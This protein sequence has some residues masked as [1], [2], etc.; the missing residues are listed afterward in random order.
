MRYTCI[1]NIPTCSNEINRLTYSEEY[2]NKLHNVKQHVQSINTC[3]ETSDLNDIEFGLRFSFLR[4]AI[5]ICI[6]MQ[7]LQNYLLLEFR[8]FNV[9]IKT[10]KIITKKA[11]R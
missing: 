5:T 4:F 6:H 10:L 1:Q 7:M 3:D 9:E 8:L 11:S 2:Q